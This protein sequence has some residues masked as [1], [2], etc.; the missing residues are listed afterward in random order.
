MKILNESREVL[1]NKMIQMEAE[2][3]LSEIPLDIPNADLILSCVTYWIRY[4]FHLQWM[5]DGW[6]GGNAN[7]FCALSKSRRKRCSLLWPKYPM[8]G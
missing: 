6:R 3:F 5:S 4:V 2:E 8:S 1:R 7:S